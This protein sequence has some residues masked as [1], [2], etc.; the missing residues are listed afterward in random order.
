MVNLPVLSSLTIQHYFISSNLRSSSW[1][2]C[3]SGLTCSSASASTPTPMSR[4]NRSMPMP[5]TMSMVF[6]VLPSGSSVRLSH[7][8][9]N[10]FISLPL[11]VVVVVVERATLPSLC[12][13]LGLFQCSCLGDVMSIL[14]YVARCL[15]SGV[16]PLKP[17]VGPV[18]RKYYVHCCSP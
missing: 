13:A 10:Q 17:I 3:H 6:H 8:I 7:L 18:V 5:C 4:K 2:G 14:E 16:N 12:L 1:L 15:Q 11:C 9:S